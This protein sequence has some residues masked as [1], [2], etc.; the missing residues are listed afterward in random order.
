[1]R[2]GAA[3]GSSALAPRPPRA[4]I[5]TPLG[6]GLLIA[7]AGCEGASGDP[8]AAWTGTMDTLPSGQVVVENTAEPIWPEDGGWRVVEE[9]RI[10][11][12]EGEGPD[13][14][15][16][17]GSM[18]VDAAG[19]PWLFDSQA[20]ELRVFSASGEHVRTV[21]RRGGAPGEFAQAVRV[22]RG[23]DGGMWVMD[24]QNNRISIFDTA[25]TYVDAKPAL[26]GF[27]I[28]PWPGGFDDEGSYYAPVPQGGRD[29]RIAL[30]RYDSGFAARD[31]LQPPAY[32]VARES[33]EHRTP[34]GGMMMAG[35]PYQGGL[36]WQLSRPGTIWALITEE[37]RLF[38]LA[39][40]GDTLRSII[41]AFEPQPVTAADREAA[42]ENLKWFTD[43]GG[44]IDLSRIPETKPPVSSFFRDDDGHIWV[45][46]V[47]TP[48]QSGRVHDVFDPEGR[49]LGTVEL[50]FPLS[51]SPTPIVRDGMLYGVTADELGVQYVVRARI[52]RDAT[53]DA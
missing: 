36:T 2:T 5:L 38:E 14:F 15:G 27:I 13:V 52:E 31:T 43:Q 30:V 37:Y 25:G 8:A 44:Q 17:I 19:R 21:G 29:F 9:L 45:A 33:F 39:P 24:P 51:R 34:G 4:A 40:G 1:M 11:R 6:L 42:R 32:D 26:G 48:E 12:M 49:F 20:Q 28:M 46:R 50:P 18:E 10:G 35:V 7:A 3:R 47:T 41:R 53:P 23:P 16:Q 22:E